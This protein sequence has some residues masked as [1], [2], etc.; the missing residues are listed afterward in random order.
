SCFAAQCNAGNENASV[1]ATK[2]TGSRPSSHSRIRPPNSSSS[3]ARVGPRAGFG[4]AMPTP[5]RSRD[6]LAQQRPLLR[7]D[8][9]DIFLGS[10]NVVPDSPR[11]GCTAH[12]RDRTPRHR[13]LVVPVTRLVY[14]CHCRIPFA[15][16]PT[17]G[18]AAHL[19][20]RPARRRSSAISLR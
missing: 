14:L 11:G 18:L 8:G 12:P 3:A 13:F 7:L 1:P 16:P 5:R 4:L 10:R 6:C 17:H 9:R 20:W 2:T 19:F 15:P